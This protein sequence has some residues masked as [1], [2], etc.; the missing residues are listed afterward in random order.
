MKIRFRTP[1][2]AT[3]ACAES[4]RF[5]FQELIQ[6]P[7]LRKHAWRRI[8]RKKKVKAAMTL[9]AASSYAVCLN[10]PKRVRARFWDKYAE[11]ERLWIGRAMHTRLMRNAT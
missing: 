7:L 1:S 5:G 3:N 11:W 10:S 6:P 9:A 8:F 4:A 2:S